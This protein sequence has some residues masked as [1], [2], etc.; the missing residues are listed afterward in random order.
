MASQHMAS[1]VM[2]QLIWEYSI[3]V[4]DI[5]RFLTH[6]F[7][8][9]EKHVAVTF[10]YVNDKTNLIEIGQTEGEDLDA[11]DELF[12]LRNKSR[13]DMTIFDDDN[14]PSVERGSGLVYDPDEVTDMGS[15]NT[16]AYAQRREANNGKDVMGLAAMLAE[17]NMKGAAG[18]SDLED[19]SED[20][21]ASVEG[22]GTKDN[23]IMQNSE[24]V[25][26]TG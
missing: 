3:D 15:F 8:R 18:T 12:E 16:T 5:L 7:D 11:D 14:K 1:L 6:M 17:A 26:D 4:E 19:T 2:T 21:A 20:D 9:T 13:I 24:H 22:D 23:V 25:E 10:S